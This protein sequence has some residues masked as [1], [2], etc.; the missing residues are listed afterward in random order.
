MVHSERIRSELLLLQEL[1]SLEVEYWYEVDHNWGRS[2]HT[3]YVPGGEFTIGEKTMEGPDA[4]HAFYKWREDRGDRAARHIV[5]N[6]RLVSYDGEQAKFGCILSLHAADGRP[7]LPS[8]APIMIADIH[9]DCVRSND[10]CWR[11]RS[12]RLVPI[13][14]GSTPTTIPPT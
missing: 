4:V 1:S 14:T 11:F 13:F 7:P 12:H 6:F 2:A 8:E 10:G 5:T 9:S 3:Y